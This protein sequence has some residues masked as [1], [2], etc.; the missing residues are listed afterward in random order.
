MSTLAQRHKMRVLAAQVSAHAAPGSVMTAR[1]SS[2]HALIRAQLDEHRRQLKRME[3]IERKV[4]AKATMLPV[5]VDY[6]NGVLAADNGVQD[7]VLGFVMLW[8]LDIGDYPGALQIGAYVLKHGLSMPDHFERKPAC[9][10][11]EEPAEAALRA[12]KAGKPFDVAVLRQAWRLTKDHD[13]PDQVRAKLLFALG[14]HLMEDDPAQALA[15]LQR[16]VELHD[17]V[18]AKKDIEQLER[19]LRR[20]AVGTAGRS[21]PELNTAGDKPADTQQPPTGGT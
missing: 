17:G 6:V 5:Y 9:T 11:A 1:S 19:R 10:F 20:D 16:A 15:N 12:Y 21:T 2:A 3:S 14:R 18:G 8:R 4:A 13:M 7:D